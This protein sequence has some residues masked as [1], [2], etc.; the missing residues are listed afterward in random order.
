MFKSLLAKTL[1]IILAGIILITI[2]N[3]LNTNSNLLIKP[4]SAKRVWLIK[5]VDTMKYS[6]DLSLEK[7]DEP[8]FNLTIDSQIK[9]IKNLNAN[10]VALGT[11]YDEKFIPILT[12]WVNSARKNGLKVWFRGN[13]SAWEGWFGENKNSI[14]RDD[15]IQKTRDF[16]K[17]NPDLFK[18][19]DIFSSC[20]ECENGGPGDPRIN[21]DVKGHRSFLI[22]ERNAALEEFA[23]IGKKVTVLDSM[24]FDVAKQ[25]MDKETAEAMGGIV[26]IDH[27]VK[28]PQKLADDV[29]YLHRQTDA[30]I[31][32]GEFGVPIPD[33]H[34][35]LNPQQQVQ[36]TE[37]ALKLLS[38]KKHLIGLNY[39]VGIGGSTAIFNKDLTPKPAAEMLKKYFSLLNLD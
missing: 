13:F 14:S 10:Y 8:L 5:S 37:E 26:V 15:H 25:L 17:N 12:R 7:L 11:P 19:G 27:Y 29:D 22:T 3:N 31:F 33:I 20:P 4:Q 39:W 23:K 9:V 21:G 16:I 1:I 28:T 6:R 32:L 34:G 38:G 30:Q 18:N 2:F 24:N 36:W 35:D